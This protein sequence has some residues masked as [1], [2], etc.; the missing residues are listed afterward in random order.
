LPILEISP[1]RSYN[2]STSI[3]FQIFFFR[4]PLMSERVTYEDSEAQ[5][6]DAT[7]P[8]LPPPPLFRLGEVPNVSNRYSQCNPATMFAVV[9]Q[10]F[11]FYFL[12]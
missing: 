8:I 3:F 11:F 2:Y 10:A 7:Q 6:W 4:N 9:P 12:K 1:E 5:D